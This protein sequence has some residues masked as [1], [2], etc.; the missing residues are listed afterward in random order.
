MSTTITKVR[1]HQISAYLPRHKHFARTLAHRLIIDSFAASKSSNTSFELSTI[2]N[3]KII[4]KATTAT[5]P[6]IHTLT[7][8]P[9]ARGTAGRSI[10]KKIP[11]Y[12]L[13]SLFSTARFRRCLFAAGLLKI[14]LIKVLRSHA[15]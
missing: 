7:C 10:E 12:I 13:I 2:S 8:K 9:M 3:R 5:A 6:L 1:Q 14:A 15:K 11:F 4:D